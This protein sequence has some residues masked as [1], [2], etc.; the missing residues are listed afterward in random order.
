[1][2][3]LAFHTVMLLILMDQTQHMKS[4]LNANQDECTTNE[5][6]VNN[7]KNRSLYKGMKGVS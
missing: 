1:M 7:R 5:D 6:N 3:S 2:E 4:S